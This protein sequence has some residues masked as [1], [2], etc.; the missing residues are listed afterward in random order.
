MDNKIITAIII[1]IIALLGGIFG[2][3]TLSN[4]NTTDTTLNTTNNTTVVENGEYITVDPPRTNDTFDFVE[5]IENIDY[6]KQYY[7]EFVAEDKAMYV[8]SGE[9]ILEKGVSVFRVGQDYTRTNGRILDNYGTEV[10]NGLSK[11][12]TGGVDIDPDTTL[13]ELIL[14]ETNVPDGGFWYVRTMFFANKTIDANRTQVAYP[15]ASY[16]QNPKKAIYIRSWQ[17]GSWTSWR[18]IGITS[19][20]T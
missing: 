4:S 12:K 18:A 2:T 11:Y 8:S 10:V 15:Y 16:L 17:N 19:S 3:G 20:A 13:E 6:Q 9:R 5:T 14:T 7:F 1:I